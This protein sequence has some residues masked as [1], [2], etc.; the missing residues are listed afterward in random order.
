MPENAPYWLT[1]IFLVGSFAVWIVSMIMRGKEKERLHR[2]RMLLLEK[3]LEVPGRIEDTR[4][5]ARHDPQSVR[6]GLRL[7]GTFFIIVGLFPV[8]VIAIN[9]GFPALLYGS[10]M[11]FIGIALLV[12]ERVMARGGQSQPPPDREP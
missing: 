4:G 2:E 3:G 9:K 12:C 11:L 8:M 10:S 5:R 6:E 7:S 1:V